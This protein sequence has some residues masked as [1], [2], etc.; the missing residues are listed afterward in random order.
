MITH[1]PTHKW[2]QAARVQALEGAGDLR[3]KA[4][5]RRAKGA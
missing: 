2:Q 4:R 3:Q 1:G 5:D